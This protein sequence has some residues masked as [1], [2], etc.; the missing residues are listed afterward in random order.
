MFLINYIDLISLDATFN[1][2]KLIKW[3]KGEPSDICAFY[4]SSTINE[5]NPLNCSNL[6]FKVLYL[7]AK[8][9]SDYFDKK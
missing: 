1:S 3:E 5:T 4:T 2:S 9:N 7:F 8:N 6:N